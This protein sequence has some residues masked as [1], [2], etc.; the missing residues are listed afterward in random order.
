MALEYFYPIDSHKNT[1]WKQLTVSRINTHDVSI[2]QG[3]LFSLNLH[4]SCFPFSAQIS[5][6][7]DRVCI[8]IGQISTNVT[9][10]ISFK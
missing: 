6:V 2:S 7:L 8:Y 1:K 9:S 5:L 4:V 3:F 10:F